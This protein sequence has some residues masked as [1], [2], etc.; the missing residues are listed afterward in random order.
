MNLND[1]K[2]ILVV[3]DHQ[4]VREG[5][6]SLLA[7]W[8]P[9]WTVSE[10]GSGAQA[11]EAIRERV[12][13]LAI[14]DVTMPDE[15]G[16]EVASRLRAS[17]FDRP[18]LIF[19]MHQSQRLARDVKEAGGQGFVLKAQA[20]EDLVRAVGILLGGGTFFGGMPEPETGPNNPTPGTVMFFRGFALQ[21]A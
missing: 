6:R 4:I 14:I 2:T 5:V 8:R 21:S 10:A 11:M 12:P 15:N 13:D 20:T 16:F 3:D 1:P 7:A 17:G 18:I 9:A 19:T